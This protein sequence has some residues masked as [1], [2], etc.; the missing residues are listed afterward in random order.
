M[1]L[2]AGYSQLTAFGFQAGIFAQSSFYAGI[3]ANRATHLFGAF[4]REKPLLPPLPNTVG[5]KIHM[6]GIRSYRVIRHW[7]Q[8]L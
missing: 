2:S 8:Y 6:D 1:W 4:R 5:D 3:A 7:S